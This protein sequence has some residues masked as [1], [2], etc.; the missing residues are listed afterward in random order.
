MREN[1]G[2]KPPQYPSGQGEQ[3]PKCPKAEPVSLLR[4]NRPARILHCDD[5]PTVR[6]CVKLMLRFLF[7]DYHL[8]Q[9]DSGYATL[10]EV[11]R[12]KPD[13]L[14]TDCCHPG[15]RF[16]E[17]LPL[18]FRRRARFPI[19]VTSAQIGPRHIRKH[20]LSFPTFEIALLDKPFT[21]ANLRVKVLKCL[22]P[23][24]DPESEV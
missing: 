17:T 10:R 21:V 3:A 8:A 4:G 6:D 5:E 1:N 22:N 16:E 15:L 24:T 19:L 9:C 23:A 7:K 2:Q 18:L 11:T 12:R 20:L 14:I 13:L